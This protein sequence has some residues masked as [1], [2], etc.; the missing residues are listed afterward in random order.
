MLQVC[1]RFKVPTHFKLYI[2]YTRDGQLNDTRGP[3]LNVRKSSGPG[4]I[5]SKNK[6]P[7]VIYTPINNIISFTF[8]SSILDK[9]LYLL[10]TINIISVLII[11]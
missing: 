9:N 7:N 3:I 2:P 6:K 1:T 8:N 11:L 4:N 10:F 5:E